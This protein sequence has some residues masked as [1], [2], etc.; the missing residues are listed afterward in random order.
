MN[1]KKHVVIF[2][3]GFGV[4]KEA[5]GLFPEIASVLTGIVSIFFDYN[6]VSE[7]RKTITARLLSEQV[8]IFNEV[9]EKTQAENPDAVVDI[10][11]HSRGCVVVA[12]ARPTGIRKTIFVTPPY[13]ND[14]NRM[15]ELFKDRPGSHVDLFGISRLSRKDGTTT[16]VPSEYWQ[17]RAGFDNISLYNDFSN[18]TELMIIN[19]KQDEVLGEVDMNGLDKKIQINDINGNHNFFGDTRAVLL[20][21]IKGFIQ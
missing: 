14:I 18:Y 9:L 17:E 15:V 7:D 20:D 21:T 8:K 4:D 10:V 2:S 16:I 5:R 6:E 1:Q 11:A 19:A 3:H 12:D 13:D